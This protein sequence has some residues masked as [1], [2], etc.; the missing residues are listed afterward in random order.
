MKKVFDAFPLLCWL[1]EEPG[2]KKVDSYLTQAAQGSLEIVISAVN[3]GE[4]YYRLIRAVGMQKAEIFL[5]NI[6]HK[7]FPLTVVPV[8]NSRVWRAARIKGSY[9]VSYADAFAVALAKELNAPLV[10]GDPEILDLPSD[11]VAIDP[12]PSLKSR[13]E[14]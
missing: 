6:R 5:S 7:V 14:E 3:V 4:I 11:L 1:Q 9:R 13:P 12:L 10:T 2:W 8:T